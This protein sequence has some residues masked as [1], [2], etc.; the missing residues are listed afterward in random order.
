MYVLTE[1]ANIVPHNEVELPDEI[2]VARVCAGED[3]LF[4]LLYQRYRARTFALAYGMTGKREQADDLTQDIFLR[5]Y[6]RLSTFQGH[7]KFSTWFY[8][9]SLNCCLNYCRHERAS[10]TRLSGAETPPP[11]LVKVRR[12]EEA[13]EALLRQEVQQQIRVALLS[14]KPQMRMLLVLKE[15]EGLSYDEISERLG[16][17][18]GTVASRLNRARQLLGRKLESLKGKI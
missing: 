12:T 5:V 11:M 2:I 17:S 9:I 14:L 3:A 6:Q 7:A 16:C 1:S 13:H 8:R 4:A 10:V 18:T 15:I